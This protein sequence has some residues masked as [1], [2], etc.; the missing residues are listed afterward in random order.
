[1]SKYLFPETVIGTKDFFFFF[2]FLI[3]KQLES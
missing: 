1:M 2:F 3:Y